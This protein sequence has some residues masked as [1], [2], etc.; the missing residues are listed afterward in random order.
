MRSVVPT[1]FFFLFFILFLLFDSF[2][3]EFC[4][5]PLSVTGNRCRFKLEPSSQQNEDDD[6]V[7]LGFTYFSWL[8]L[9]F[10]AFYRDV[11]VFLLGFSSFYWTLLSF[12]S[13]YP[14]WRGFAGL[15]LLLLGFTGVSIH[16]FSRFY[17]VLLGFTQFYWYVPGFTKFYSIESTFYWVLLGFTGFFYPFYRV[18]PVFF[19]RFLPRL[20]DL[21]F[22]GFTE[23]YLQFNWIRFLFGGGL[24]M[25]NQ[26]TQTPNC[27]IHLENGCSFFL[28]LMFFLFFL[29]VIR[30]SSQVFT[31][32]LWSCDW[33]C[34]SGSWKKKIFVFFSFIFFFGS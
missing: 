4:C 13:F 3:T 16:V 31:V 24:I 10:I 33:P 17:L 26:S 15:N 22:S 12:F 21:L 6:E 20:Y 11:P 14:T 28:S 23:F 34:S 29:L 30:A 2:D 18:V 19:S 25:R 5:L 27:S 7:L 9:V 32:A 1:C 8:V